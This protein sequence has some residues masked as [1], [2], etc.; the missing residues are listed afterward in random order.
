MHFKTE[1]SWP[2][3]ERVGAS[4]QKLLASLTGALM[5]A[6][7][8]PLAA[9][10]QPKRAAVPIVTPAPIPTL[11]PSVTQ[12]RAQSD[13]PQSVTLQQAI[14]IAAEKSPVLAAARANYELT[15]IPVR[16]ARTAVFPN[17]SASATQTH[18]NRGSVTSSNGSFVQGGFSGTTRGLNA[19]LR[20]LIYDGGKFIAQIHQ[21]KASAVAGAET[22]QRDL[23]TLSF[24]VAQAYYTAL[25]DRTAATLAQQ[26]V[27]QNEVQENLV[28]AQLRA[29]VAS[30]VDVATAA[31]PVAQAR[32]ASVRAQGNAVSALAAFAN[33]L[34]LDADIAVA[35]VNDTPANPTQSLVT[36]LPYQQ[37]VARALALRP[38]YLAAEETVMAQQ[39]NVQVQRAGYYPSLSGTATYGTNSTTPQGTNFVPGSSVGFSLAIPIFDQGVTRAQIEQAQAQLDLAQSQST[40][41]RL[42][43][44]LAVRQALVG[45][46][47]AQGQV[48]ETQAELNQ[49]QTVL[50]ATQ[51]QYRAGVTTL[52]LLL[53]AQVQLTTAQ[54]DQLT[55][56]YNLRQA[57][58]TYIFALGESSINPTP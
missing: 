36:A 55:A 53:N 16:L 50:S 27:R 2:W 5:L 42:G 1:A 26:V 29:G 12:T 18:S 30:R 41:T 34:G 14:A 19:T 22:Y 48:A 44:E 33:Q 39:Y 15:Q 25:A 8:F 17:I 9:P 11:P 57:E 10:A 23:E 52:P 28:L 35:P 32:V 51:A 13:V 46:V 38:D 21:A 37:S 54:S 6:A 7:L 3:R 31:V 43:V 49:A 56:V 47:S 40:Q 24:N 58:Q 45:L 4:V 20:Q